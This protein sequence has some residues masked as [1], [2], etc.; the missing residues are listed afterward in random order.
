MCAQCC[1]ARNDDNSAG[2]TRRERDGD[3]KVTRIFELDFETSRKCWQSQF[4]DE[5]VFSKVGTWSVA[6]SSS[7]VQARW[8]VCERKSG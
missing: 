4:E 5:M 3:C 8:E 2:F 6:G 7:C 1:F